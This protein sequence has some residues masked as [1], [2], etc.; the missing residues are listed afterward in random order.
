M[1]EESRISSVVE[2][3]EQNSHRYSDNVAVTGVGETLTFA[4]LWKQSQTLAHELVHQGVQP[5]DRVGLWANQSSDLLVGMI[6]I[7]AA[8]AAYVPLDPSY[9]KGRLDFIVNDS[10]LAMIVAADNLH[11]DASEMNIPVISTKFNP[12]MDRSDA[13]LPELKESSAAY[14][15]Y[16]SGSTGR[17][18]GVVI[19]HHSVVALLQ[20]LSVDFELRPGDQVMGTA[21]PAFDA[22]VINVFMPLVTGGTFIA[23]TRDTVRD[24]RAL[25][26]AITNYRPRAVWA[27]PT[28]LRMLTEIEWQGDADLDIWT[29]GERTAGSVIAYIAPLV[30]TLINVYGPTETTVMVT[31]ARLHSADVESPVGYFPRHLVGV[32]LDANQ[33]PTPIGEIGELYVTGAQLARGYLNDPALTTERFTTIDIDVNHPVRA[34]RT[35]DLA[36]IRVDGSLIIVGRVDNQIKLRGYRIEPGEIEQRL[37]EYPHMLDAFVIAHKSSESDEPRLVAFLK[38]DVKI[39]IEALRSF[40]KETLPEFMVPTVF[41]EIDEFPLAPTG[42]VDKHQLEKL[43]SENV[44]ADD[45][46]NNPAFSKRV[47]LEDQQLSEL[48]TSV[49]E[50][51]ADALN[52]NGDAIGPDDDFFDLGGT[53]VR[54]MRLFMSIEE[55]YNVALPISTLVNASTVRLLAA[56]IEKQTDPARSQPTVGDTSADEWEWV[57]CILWSEIL[58]VSEVERLDNFFD[59]GGTTTEASRMIKELKTINGTNAT[60]AELRK[61]PTVAEFA[62]LTQGRST[63]S[64]LVPL[65]TS[66]TNT[67]FFC[68][69]GPGGLALGFLP[70]SR[71]LGREQPFYGLQAHGIE[72]RGLPDFTLGQATTRYTKLIREVQPHGP[73]LIGGHSY[74][75]AVALK[76]AQHLKAQGEDVALLVIFDTILPSR[77]SGLDEAATYQTGEERHPWWHKFKPPAKLSKLIRLPLVGLVR[78]PGI[79]QFEMFSLHGAIQVWFGRRLEQWSGKS[80]VYVSDTEKASNIE[81]SWECLLTGQWTCVSV[82]GGHWGLL[83]RPH[84]DILA[85]HLHDEMKL[86]LAPSTGDADQRNISTIPS[87]KRNVRLSS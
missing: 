27:S 34:Y 76:V 16:T 51:F 35:G 37:I 50:L 17:P 53:S 26:I 45:T 75:G 82:P 8:G 5:E 68:V 69:A 12:A 39:Q 85:T 21:S 57:L 4:E 54:C 15:I 10:G 13:T 60:I 9:P 61:A 80:I 2:W 6:G 72:R 59:L 30:R 47:S 40:V 55:R 11:D 58:K 33:Q 42:K 24:P 81:A 19:E 64:S 79:L 44:G 38:S 22:T 20:W 77:M 86:A 7:M 46:R 66:G 41:I 73:Y 43:A 56:T 1:I 29:G 49:L 32:L 63:R 18:K 83:Q 78:Q 65:N 71:Q 74:G 84:V 31:Y 67:P 25:A 62:A 14:V 36:R 28:M 70:L 23:L 87:G 48:E 52:I 3:I